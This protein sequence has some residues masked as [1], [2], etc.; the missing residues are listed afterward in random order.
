MGFARKITKVLSEEYPTEPWERKTP[1]A[2]YRGSCYPT[3]NPDAN[4]PDTY[5]FL[6]G[7]VCSAATQDPESAQAFD[8][9]ACACVSI[10]ALLF[11]HRQAGTPIDPAYAG[12]D[13]VGY[14]GSK[15]AEGNFF[16][17]LCSTCAACNSSKPMARED[18]VNYKYQL[19]VDGYGP[20]FDAIFVRASPIVSGAL[21]SLCVQPPHSG[22]FEATAWSCTS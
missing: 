1:K 4:N 7:A 10:G 19:S 17:K 12:G 5:L 16:E 22:S 20:T 6:R 3:A 13:N 8:V 14:C 11:L 21:H 15:G 2:V 9:G 18:M